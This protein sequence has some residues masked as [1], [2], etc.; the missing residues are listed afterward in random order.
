MTAREVDR[1]AS[2]LEHIRQQRWARLL[3]TGPAAVLAAGAFVV[4]AALAVSLICGIASLLALALLDTVRHRELVSSL[5]LNPN[6]YTV[7]EVRRYG[8]D[9]VVLRGRRRVAAALERVVAN[10]G[11]PG[12][13]YLAS[14]VHA[15]RHE[16]RAL[17]EALRAPETRVEPTS[18][19]MCWRLLR[20]AAESPLYNWHLPADDLPM[21]V[22]R[23]QAGISR[24]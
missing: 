4:S 12:S 6:A 19:A 8:E 11:A 13:Y 20:N 16:L 5:A 24:R 22:R 14:R 9:L 1:A 2:Q 17:A 3:L 15:C 21:A 10:A 18:V 7:P 23:I